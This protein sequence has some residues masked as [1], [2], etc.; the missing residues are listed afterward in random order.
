MHMTIDYELSDLDD[1]SSENEFLDESLGSSGSIDYQGNQNGR[2][3]DCKVNTE[4]MFSMV[5]M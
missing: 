3:E 4:E 2:A 1:D 5:R